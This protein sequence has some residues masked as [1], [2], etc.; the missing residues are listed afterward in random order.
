MCLL[1]GFEPRLDGAAFPLRL[2]RKATG[3]LAC[4]AAAPGRSVSRD[5]LGAR[6]WGRSRPEQARHSVRQALLSTRQA[7]F[8]SG[9]ASALSV[10]EDAL[11]LD[12]AF[13]EVDVAEFEARLDDGSVAALEEAV[14][15]YRGEFLHGFD[16]GEPPFDDWA[17]GERER[18]RERARHGLAGL[19][20]HHDGRGAVEPA[21]ETAL[22][23]LRV[24]RTQERV[25][26]TLIQL[27]SR[28]GRRADAL[29]QYRACVGML[30]GEL[31]VE[32][33]PETVR[34][35]RE[36]LAPRAPARGPVPEP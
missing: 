24:D 22:R 14:A 23:L 15:L 7:L 21:I 35:Y 10:A 33:A 17:R 3:L 36:I 2:P 5:T 12:P 32:P 20:V 9:C 27:Y 4:L 30:R 29:R 19:L 26:R 11:A 34:L 8:S 18:L 16:L 25:H 6:L 13:V 31:G 28:Q 1:G